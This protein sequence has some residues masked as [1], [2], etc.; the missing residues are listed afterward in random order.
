MSSKPAPSPEILRSQEEAF[1]Q[2]DKWMIRWAIQFT[3]NDRARAE[4]LVQEVFAQ[5]AFAHTDLSAVQN[6]PAYLY[7]SW[8]NMHVTEVRMAGR[9]HVQSLS[10]VEYSVAD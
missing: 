9:S 3:N 5:F 1:I 7:T 4:D 10:I 8:R 2:P 6:I